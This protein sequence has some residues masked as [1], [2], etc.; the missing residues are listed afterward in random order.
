MFRS[1]CG[2][3]HQRRTIA[4]CNY[5]SLIVNHMYLV[6]VM[7]TEVLKLP[8]TARTSKTTFINSHVRSSLCPLNRYLF[9]VCSSS[10]SSSHFIHYCL[11]KNK[12]AE[13]K[14]SQM[15]DFCP[16]HFTFVPISAF[17]GKKQQWEMMDQHQH[18]LYTF[19]T[20]S[21]LHSENQPLNGNAQ[22]KRANQEPQMAKCNRT[23]HTQMTTV[24]G[25]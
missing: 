3:L 5:T 23:A 17:K 22:L 12:N 20:L 16:D 10:H 15:N 9:V 13:M 2:T 14:S 11:A 6:I 21:T 4:C 7:D 1:C 24:V 19:T 25:D 8:N 18:Q